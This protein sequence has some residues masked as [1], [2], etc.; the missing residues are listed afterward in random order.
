ML[1]LHTVP[2]AT[3]L[4]K[5]VQLDSET[6]P[7]MTARGR[8]LMLL[9]TACSWVGYFSAEAASPTGRLTSKGCAYLV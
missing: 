9:V 8:R 1:S 2:A 5:P 4:K 3:L 6:A 7:D